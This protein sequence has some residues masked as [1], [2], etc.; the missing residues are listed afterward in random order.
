MREEEGWVRDT[1]CFT[2]GGAGG[3]VEGDEGEERVGV[4]RVEVRSICISVFCLAE[5]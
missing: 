5:T 1:G 3:A 4:A 2:V